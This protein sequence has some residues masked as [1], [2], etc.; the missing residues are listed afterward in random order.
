MKPVYLMIGPAL[1][2]ACLSARAQDENKPQQSRPALAKEAP[3]PVTAPPVA[4]RSDDTRAI[5]ALVEAFT[6]AYDAGDAAAI[7]ATFRGRGPGRRRG[8]GAHPWPSRHPHDR[9]NPPQATRLQPVVRRVS[10]VGLQPVPLIL[11]WQVQAVLQPPC[12][13]AVNERRD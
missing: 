1:L 11:Y 9:L 5:G 2:G 4:D 12:L 6:K 7:A 10:P 13:P 3:P 8:G